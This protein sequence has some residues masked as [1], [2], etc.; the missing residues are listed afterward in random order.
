MLTPR[1]QPRGLGRS[2]HLNHHLLARRCKP[3][4]TTRTGHNISQRS[5]VAGSGLGIWTPPPR[6]STARINRKPRRRAGQRRPGIVLRIHAHRPTRPPPNLGQPD[7]AREG[8]VRT[9]RAVLQSSVSPFHAWPQGLCQLRHSLPG[10]TPGRGRT[11]KLRLAT[12]R[13]E[14]QQEFARFHDAQAS[15]ALS[16]LAQMLMQPPRGPP[17]MH[18]FYGC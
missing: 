17:R 10:R 14:L 9:N 3:V 13:G 18:R 5:L 11:N 2:T 6:G 1:R 8:H 4:S 15:E 16:N 12:R 7:S